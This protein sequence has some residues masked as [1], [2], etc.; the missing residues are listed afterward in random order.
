MFCRECG[1]EIPANA[2]YCISCGFRPMKSN[3]YCNWCGTQTRPNQELCVSCGHMLS[4]ETKVNYSSRSQYAGF[5]MRFVAYL[6]DGIIMLVPAAMIISSIVFFQAI[7]F[8]DAFLYDNLGWF[9]EDGIY[10]LLGILMNLFYF[11]IFHAT[12]WQAT[13]GKRILN[14]KVVDESGNRL[15]FGRSMLRSLATYIS[16]IPLYIGCILAGITER[17]QALHDIIVKTYVVKK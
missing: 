4:R 10:Y 3:H 17:K 2:E 12:K 9:W 11:G 15:S 5:W 6:I 14:L 8:Y 13:P 16:T 1:N 7:F